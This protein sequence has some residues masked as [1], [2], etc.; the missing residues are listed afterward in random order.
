MSTMWN[1]DTVRHLERD[2]IQQFMTEHQHLL[3]DQVLDYGCG[4]CPYQHLVK[5]TYHPFDIA[6]PSR[7]VQHL[8]YSAIMFNQV[9]QYIPPGKLLELFYR[10]EHWLGVGGHLV[11]TYAT[12]WAEVEASDLVRYTKAGMEH[13]MLTGA[14]CLQIIEH[15]KRAEIDLNGFKLPLG[16]GLV[17]RKR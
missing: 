11:M 9:A 17:A 1:N 13:M 7:P 15:V 10:F 16:Y 12:N 14:P 3:I 6:A 5:G 8:R 2:S 4:K